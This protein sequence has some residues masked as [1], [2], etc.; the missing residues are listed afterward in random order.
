MVLTMGRKWL[1]S[2]RMRPAMSFNG[3]NNLPTSGRWLGARMEQ[4]NVLN[5]CEGRMRCSWVTFIGRAAT[6][7]RG[8]EEING[9]GGG[10][11][12]W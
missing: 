1:G 12:S 3:S 7:R 2:D 6:S 9:G 10:A 5:G 11:F 4:D 8:G